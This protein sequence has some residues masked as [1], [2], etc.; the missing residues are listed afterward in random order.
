MAV[1]AGTWATATASAEP[2]ASAP[3]T[4]AVRAALPAGMVGVNPF[5]LSGGFTVY[6]IDDA[7]LANTEFEGSIA[8][9]DQLRVTQQ[10]SYQFAHVIAGTGSYVLPTIDGDPTRVLA[11][12]YDPNPATN[13]GRV[14]IT[15]AGA[16]EPAQVGDLKLV[17]R[18]TPFTSF[19]RASWLRYALAQGSDT[20]PLIDAQNQE[21][22]DD[23]QPPTSSAGDGSIY[24]Y[25]TGEDTA[26]VVASYVQANAQAREDEID[27]CLIDIIDPESPNGYPVE[28]A[29]DAGDRIV[30]GTLSPDQPNIVQ[31]ADIA[32]A[33]LLQFSDGT[34]GPSNPL[35]IHVEPGTT[36]IL[37]PAID[38]EGT[39]SPY[40]LWDLSQVSGPVAFS[41]DG[42]GDG[43][44]YAPNAD[45]SII[46]QPW[47][48]QIIANSVMIA[49]GEV[50]S[51]LFAGGLPCDAPV[52]SGTFSVAK[53]LAGVEASALAPGTVF[54]VRYL[55]LAPDGTLSSGLLE[56]SPDG[57]PVSPGV[58]FPFGTRVAVYELP[59][60]DAALPPE[61]AWS[62]VSWSGDTSFTIDS[63]HPSVSLVVTDTAALV[64]AGFSVTKSLTG[65]GATAVPSGEEFTVEYTVN[66]G[67][68]T[69]LVIR[70]DEPALVDDLVAG[71]VVT[72]SELTPPE[73]EGIAWGTPTWTVGG[74]PVVPGENG[75]I[76]FTLVGG[77]TIAVG[78]TNT[79]E[80]VGWV[81]I[82]KTVIGDGVS[83][84]P[85]G[86]EFPLVYSLDGGP[87]TTAAIPADEV[88]TVG[89]IP[90]GTVV[91]VREGTLPDVPG[92]AWG[93][94]GWTVDGVPLV[95]DAA[96]NVT[97]VVQ[98]GSTV[99]LALTN[100][101]N[102]F[103]SLSF[104][105]TL[106]GPASDLV[107]ADTVYPI[108]YRVSEGPVT[109]GEV[110]TG[111]PVEASGFPTGVA[112]WARE[113]APP[114]IPGVEWGEPQW[115]IDGEPVTP[116]ADGW[117]TFMAETGTTVEI[118]LENDAEF[119]PGGFTVT[120]AITGDGASV[121]PPGTQFTV[122]YRVD[123]GP[124]QS[125]VVGV[126]EPATVGDL[127]LGST[128][129]FTE[130]APPEVADIEW[131]TPVWKVDGVT[132]S[133]PTITIG[134]GQ[135]VAVELQNTADAPDTPG[136]LPAAGFAAGVPLTVAA[137]AVLLG[138]ALLAARSRSR[139]SRSEQGSA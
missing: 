120:K 75:E 66:G 93:T 9:G 39:Y 6:A 49:G 99:A 71:D 132:V 77:E 50:H 125:L 31:Y 26:S 46:A 91:T 43:S 92:V 51:Y 5:T 95:P 16:T 40:V 110:T 64:P 53:E 119:G 89:G 52:D 97:F 118:A 88:I 38:P 78:L 23:A 54:E 107:P 103:G 134:A 2:A 79:A 15:S 48:G 124:E 80:A 90:A 136:S 76:T 7:V 83:V 14:E 84:L 116:D 105:K 24:T 108:E 100:T 98:P 4:A 45:L 70:P 87:E 113:G 138:L 115:T 129:T 12:S 63:T 128:V 106:T 13:S 82:S 86:L 25:D 94:P 133:D 47:D 29:E 111:R 22:P 56:L 20:P 72:I 101:A 127:P 30:L 42:R 67:A 55:A 123:D 61:L 32:G 58:D 122:G 73:V 11:G 28:I 60:D 104:V 36:S 137:I 130:A 59:P 112:V 114:E 21:Y 74:E 135:V 27:Q 17:D 102:G 81:S 8:V 44:I 33:R 57:T 121:V 109:T 126:G 41:T 62:E 96:G 68:P 3:R 117:V 18:T 139:G 1:L 69:D 35:V 65:S 37:P 85:D 19:T 34:P 131:G 10:A